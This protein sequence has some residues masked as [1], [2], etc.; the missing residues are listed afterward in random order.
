MEA[1]S[2]HCIYFGEYIFIVPKP[3]RCRLMTERKRRHPVR[4]GSPVDDNALGLRQVAEV[5]ALIRMM[6]RQDELATIEITWRR[7]KV[8]TTM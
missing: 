3:S 8:E 6:G 5:G 2:R 1:E 7:W 4:Q